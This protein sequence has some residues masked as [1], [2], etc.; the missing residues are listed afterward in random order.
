MHSP[1]LPLSLSPSFMMISTPT[2]LQHPDTL[3]LTLIHDTL[4]FMPL[5]YVCVVISISM[6]VQVGHT[7]IFIS[8]SWGGLWGDLVA[9]A[10][11]FA[12]TNGSVDETSSISN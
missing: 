9:A 7:D 4:P 1:S 10:A 3:L 2:I 5:M 8:H 12:D 11:S 6:L